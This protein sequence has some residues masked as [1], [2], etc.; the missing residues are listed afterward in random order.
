M[1]SRAAS[2]A[3]SQPPTAVCFPPTCRII[4]DKQKSIDYAS[5][6]PATNTHT[7]DFEGKA[8]FSLQLGSWW[9]AQAGRALSISKGGREKK[10]RKGEEKDGKGRGEGE[11]EDEGSKMKH[12]KAEVKDGMTGGR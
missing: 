12:R 7:P 1:G 4:P 3:K 10:G 11:K 9:A 2:N 5:P 6:P 8:Q